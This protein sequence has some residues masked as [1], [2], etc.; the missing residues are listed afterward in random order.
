[1]QRVI[2]LFLMADWATMAL[3]CTASCP[4]FNQQGKVDK[5]QKLIVRNARLSTTLSTVNVC[6]LSA[7]CFQNKKTKWQR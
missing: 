3:D 7:E 1:M 5:N 4:D 6:N 2:P